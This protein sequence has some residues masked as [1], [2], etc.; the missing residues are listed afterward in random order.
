M[1]WTEMNGWGK[2]CYVTKKAGRGVLTAIGVVFI[3]AEWLIGKGR[4][5]YPQRYTGKGG[6]SIPARGQGQTKKPGSWSSGW[7]S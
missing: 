4:R 3:I 6:K 5:D 2:T 7:H 1:K